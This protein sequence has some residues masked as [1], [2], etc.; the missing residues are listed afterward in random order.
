MPGLTGARAFF[1]ASLSSPML[2]N[3]DTDYGVAIVPLLSVSIN[4]F[5]KI[6]RNDSPEIAR[7]II[8][9]R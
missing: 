4:S 9:K 8:A 3:A 6:A 5:T 2:G 7:A 1:R